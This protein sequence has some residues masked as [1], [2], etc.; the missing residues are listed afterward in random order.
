MK[1]ALYWTLPSNKYLE[2]YK[3][4]EQDKNHKWCQDC[5]HFYYDCFCGYKS[6]NCRIYGSLDIDQKER[7][8]AETANTCEDYIHK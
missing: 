5:K 2:L 6:C 4:W 3:Q 8:P 1:M 7:H